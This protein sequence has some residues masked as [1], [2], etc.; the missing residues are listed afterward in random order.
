MIG[1]MLWVCAEVC[2]GHLSTET[3]TAI[4][5]EMCCLLIFSAFIGTV[6]SIAGVQILVKR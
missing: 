6:T 1:E 3:S 2:Y 5:T 4:P